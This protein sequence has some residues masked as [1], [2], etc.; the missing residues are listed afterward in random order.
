MFRYFLIIAAIFPVILIGAGNAAAQIDPPGLFPENDRRAEE[1][2]RIKEMLSK[3]QAEKD[4]RDHEELLKRGDEA[5]SLSNQLEK[6]FETNNTLTADDKR[7]LESLEKL[8]VKIRNELGGDDDSEEVE[9]EAAKPSTLN[10][11]FRYL[12]TTTVQLVDELKKTTRFSISAV[13]IQT[14]NSLIR[15]TRFLRLRK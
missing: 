4:K 3:Q 14:S 7:K 2:R 5:L 9:K 15:L 10:E 11:A 1:N 6:S 12:Q 8:V 13:A